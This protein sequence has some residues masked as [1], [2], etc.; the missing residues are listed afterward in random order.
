MEIFGQ[1]KGDILNNDLST[2][3]GVAEANVPKKTFVYTEAEM[4][5]QPNNRSLHSVG[6][7][8]VATVGQAPINKKVPGQFEMWQSPA[9]ETVLTW[10]FE[11]DAD[12]WYL[13]QLQGNR[14]TVASTDKD[15]NTTV[16][17]KGKKEK[18]KDKNKLSVGDLSLKDDLLKRI[19]G[20]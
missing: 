5:Y 2:F 15:F 1:E 16:A 3:G 13:F 12:N 7:P 11:L 6:Q 9:G 10:Y 14:L 4:E 8:S 18:S 20:L 17:K 19:S